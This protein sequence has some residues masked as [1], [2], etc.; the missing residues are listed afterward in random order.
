MRI[1]VFVFAFLLPFWAFAQA[2]STINLTIINTNQQKAIPHSAEKAPVPN[3]EVSEEARRMGLNVAQPAPKLTV[4][5]LVAP[6]DP[7]VRPK[8]R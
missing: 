3:T 1:L 8:G 6:L 5:R 2:D 4:D 7:N